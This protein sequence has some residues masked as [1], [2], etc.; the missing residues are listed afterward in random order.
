MKIKNNIFIDGSSVA[1]FDPILRKF[2]DNAGNVVLDY[3]TGFGVVDITK[4]A[5]AALI[6]GNTVV[7]N[8]K[9]SITDFQDRDTADATTRLIVTGIANNAISQNGYWL[10]QTKNKPFSSFI[11]SAG[12]AGSVDQITVGSTDLMTSAVSYAT[13]RYN[14]LVNVATNVNANTGVSGFR[15][16]VIQGDSVIDLPAMIIERITAGVLTDA[17]V[18][19]TTTLTA[20]Q[21]SVMGMGQ[22]V[23]TQA[24]EISYD[25]TVDRI[26]RCFDGQYGNEMIY[27]V[28]TLTTLGYNPITEFRWG[29]SNFRNWLFT[30]TDYTNVFITSPTSGSNQIEQNNKIYDGNFKNVILRRTNTAFVSFSNNSMLNFSNVQ[31]ATAFRCNGNSCQILLD[32]ITSPSIIITSNVGVGTC[33]FGT[34]SFSTSINITSNVVNGTLSVFGAAFSLTTFSVSNT[35]IQTGQVGFTASTT[36]TAS[37][38]ITNSSINAGL[39]LPSSGTKIF[40]IS[41]DKSTLIETV[42]QTFDISTASKSLTLVRCF[43]RNGFTITGTKTDNVIFRRTE[44]LSPV[45]FSGA[46]GEMTVED[47]FIDPG[48]TLSITWDFST[49]TLV[50]ILRSRLNASVAIVMNGGGAFQVID[51]QVSYAAIT[52]DTIYI[53]KCNVD[54]LEAAIS[55]FDATDS[56]IKTSIVSQNGT[57]ILSLDKSEL[58]NSTISLVGVTVDFINSTIKN[59][60]LLEIDIDG[61]I[62]NTMINMYN[63]VMRFVHDFTAVPLVVGVPL[64]VTYLLKGFSK[65]RIVYS[66]EGLLTSPGAAELKIGYQPSNDQY[67]P[68]VTIATINATATHENSTLDQQL[69]AIDI[70]S[71]EALVDDIDGGTF[72]YIIEG[73]LLL[74]V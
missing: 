54:V 64:E 71:I 10:R 15:A 53:D 49:S 25:I 44:I 21:V 17:V 50:E 2:Y 4:A 26:T 5:L 63:V 41:I 12:A 36:F 55:S 56:T 24:L 3:S 62:S 58:V 32:S 18:V 70:L 31:G 47:S 35:D 38:S 34:A 67:L 11:L 29:H 51:S 30:N 61:T 57:G 48:S 66:S 73:N 69:S 33:R 39:T 37:I 59:V 65:K 16:I 9:Y 46:H 40:S 28:S 19:N 14:T 74:Q 43:F 52:C 22:A 13:S 23:V 27:D 60:T 6:A 1:S 45:T 72:T 20:S 42:F 7:K 8:Q 68:A